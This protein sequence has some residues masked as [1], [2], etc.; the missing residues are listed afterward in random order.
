MH[1]DLEHARQ[2]L[3]QVKQSL[4]QLEHPDPQERETAQR[5]AA[6]LHLARLRV[7]IAWGRVIALERSSH[8]HTACEEVPSIRLC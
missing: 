2:T 3:E 4:N 1:S 8:A 7:S 5:H 6:A